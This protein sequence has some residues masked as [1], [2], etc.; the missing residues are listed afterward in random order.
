VDNV[1]SF[2]SANFV[3]RQLGYS[4]TDVIAG[5]MRADHVTQDFFSPLETF[6]PRFSSLLDDILTVGLRHVD[7]WM[8]HLNPSW[9]SDAHIEIA[10]GALAA[11]GLQ[12]VS[13]AGRFG[14]TREEF[15]R[16]CSLATA[17]DVRVLA[18]RAGILELDASFV[19]ATLEERGLVLGVENHP[20]RTPAEVLA[21]IPAGEDGHLGVAVD[22][23]WFGTQGY[24]AARAIDE[25][26]DTVVYVHLKDVRAAGG[27]ETCRYGDGVVPV[28]E[29]VAALRRIA[30][31]GPISV[32]HVPPD[33]DP[34][35]DV[36]F[37][38]GRLREWLS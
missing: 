20:E 15:E 12:A 5:W 2:N 1:V 22:T 26:G 32:E 30:Y 36:S 31:T 10:R 9:A 14:D 33:H 8:A 18:G 7:I 37:C 27:H 3:C 28:E 25:L 34:T 35:E 29:C 24:D 13:L 23:G 6:R 11:R 21:G 19:R 17:L 4:V 38:V 16:S